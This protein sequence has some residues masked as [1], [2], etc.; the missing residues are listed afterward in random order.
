MTGT[1]FESVWRERAERIIDFSMMGVALAAMVSLILEYGHYVPPQHRQIL[2]GIDVGIIVIFICETFF[3]LLIARQR[4][5][6]FKHNFVHFLVIGLL[7][8]QL[9]TVWGLSG[10]AL[11]RERLRTM[12]PGTVDT[13]HF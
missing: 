11:F 10:H 8:L 9:L 5:E 4:R 7:A 13:S 1:G 12:T 6:H 2:H 3:K